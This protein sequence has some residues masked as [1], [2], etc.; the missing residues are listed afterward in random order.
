MEDD[1]KKNDNKIPFWRPNAPDFDVRSSH[2]ID[3]YE[4]NFKKSYFW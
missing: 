2:T 3:P 4:K 1:F